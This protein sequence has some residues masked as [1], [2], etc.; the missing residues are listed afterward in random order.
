MGRVY[1]KGLLLLLLFINSQPLSLIY[2]IIFHPFIQ[3][4]TYYW[5]PNFQS[6]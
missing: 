4:L 1:N 6:K 2:S 5:F 3:L